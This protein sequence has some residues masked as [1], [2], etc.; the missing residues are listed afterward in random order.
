MT[1]GSGKLWLFALL[2]LMCAT[3]LPVYAGDDDK[4]P[5]YKIYIDPE[6]GKYTTEDPGAMAENAPVIQPPT[7][8]ATDAS[9]SK[10]PVLIVATG[11]AVMLLA[12]G[13]LRHQ[14]RLN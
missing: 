2:S 8:A 1:T 14:W 11:V 9:S 12:G 13:L 6:T 3:A 10:F 4:P 7:V 5:A